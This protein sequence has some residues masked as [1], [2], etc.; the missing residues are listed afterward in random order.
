EDAS[1]TLTTYT[2]DENGNTLTTDAA[3]AVTTMTWSYEDEMLTVQ[4]ST[5]G[6]VT[7]TY[8]GDHLRRKRQNGSG[9][10]KHVWDD[11]QVLLET[12]G[13]GAT[14]ARYTLTPFDY[15]DLVSMRRGNATSFYHFDVL[16]STRALT[17]GDEAVTATYL[18]DA[19][20]SLLASAGSTTNPYLYIGKLGYQQ[21]TGLSGYY[22]RRRHYQ[23]V[24]GRFVTQDPVRDPGRSEYGYVRNAPGG[25]VDPSGAQSSPPHTS[26]SLTVEPRHCTI[27]DCPAITDWEE[28]VR[29]VC[30]AL[31]RCKPRLG[32]YAR[33]LVDRIMGDVCSKANNLVVYCDQTSKC[34]L[35]YCGYCE[36]GN[37]GWVHICPKACHGSTPDCPGGVAATLMHEFGHMVGEDSEFFPE[38]LAKCCGMG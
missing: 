36:R 17:D 27:F 14:Q 3:G 6:R 24:S 21:E 13:N 23:P 35:G 7:M 34:A 26:P 30:A 15:G 8:D 20:G 38:H 28:K 10:T 25:R 19:F 33:G 16:G 31:R 32:A 4:P 9:T 12:N 18:Y 5:G 1:G 37:E 29:A 2:Y 11:Q 22:L